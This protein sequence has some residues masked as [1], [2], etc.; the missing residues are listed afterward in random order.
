MWPIKVKSFE[1]LTRTDILSKHVRRSLVLDLVSRWLVAA[2]LAMFVYAYL[3]AAIPAARNRIFYAAGIAFVSSLAVIVLKRVD[4]RARGSVLLLALFVAGYLSEVDPHCF[5][6]GRSTIFFALLVAM[7]PI[8]V[9]P[10]A[11]L[12]VWLLVQVAT[13]GYCVTASA[14]YPVYT[15]VILLLIALVAWVTVSRLDLL[16]D[17]LEGE[18]QKAQG[19]LDEATTA[20][21]VIVD[22][23]R[24]SLRHARITWQQRNT[25]VASH[26]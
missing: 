26:D 15:G 8:T 24:Q 19:R 12:G 3:F 10:H 5:F 11:S 25:T 21:D 4:Y 18:R 14:P 22:M 16:V 6:Y 9:S 20:I 2:A 23:E 13:I 7:A 1:Q 17:A